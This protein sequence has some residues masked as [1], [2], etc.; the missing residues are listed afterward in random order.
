MVL[1]REIAQEALLT[2]YLTIEAEEKLRQLLQKT[3]YG[4]EDLCAFMRLQQAAINGQVK[5]ESRE[6]KPSVCQ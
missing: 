3:K 1:I 4:G 2:G 5:Q 6:L